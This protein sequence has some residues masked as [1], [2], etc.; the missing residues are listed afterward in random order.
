[1]QDSA[2]QYD[3]YRSESER[4]TE[5]SNGS[6]IPGKIFYKIPP[7]SIHKKNADLHYNDGY[8]IYQFFINICF[9]NPANNKSFL[10]KINNRIQSNQCIGNKNAAYSTDPAKMQGA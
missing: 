3:Y 8:T 6:K 1:M 5:N 10:F 9:N 7:G 4:Y 2:A